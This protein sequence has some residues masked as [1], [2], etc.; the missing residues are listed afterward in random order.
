LKSSLLA[1]LGVWARVAY[2]HVVID[3]FEMETFSYSI[4]SFTIAI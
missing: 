4:L 3:A 1:A 2:K